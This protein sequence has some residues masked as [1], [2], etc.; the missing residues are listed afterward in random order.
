VD[1]V[2]HVVA[3]HAG[4]DARV[5]PGKF[6]R[7]AGDGFTFFRATASLFHKA[8]A[9]EADVAA[10]SPTGWVTGDMHIENFG[11]YKG[12]HRH[13]RLV[14]FDITDFDEAALAPAAVDL[15]RFLASIMAARA[16]LKLERAAATRLMTLAQ[17]TYAATLAEGKPF[18]MERETAPAPIS[19]LI[20]EVSARKRRVFLDKYS[21][22]RGSRRRLLTTERMLPLSADITPA[23]VREAARQL[24]EASDDAGYFRFRDARE[25]LAGTASL[26]RKRV[27]LLVRG[28]EDMDGNALLDLKSAHPSCVPA[29][30]GLATPAHASEAHRITGVERMAQAVPPAFLTPVTLDGR[31][32]V[33]RELQ[34]MQDR[35]DVDTLATAPDTLADA[36][37]TMA[38]VAAYAHLRGAGRAGAAPVEDWIAFGRSAAQD[39]AFVTLAT[40]LADDNHAAA[41]EFARAWKAGDPRLQGAV[42][43]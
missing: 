2:Q 17:A 27:V 33:A 24:A 16:A 20:V 6:A 4:R 7:M 41:R 18:Y 32:F 29:A 23:E 40:A 3:E 34:P 8:L 19:G 38:A 36:V 35:L 22:R 37:A 28:K 21:E 11:V 30:Y 43:G 26:G 9:R 14:Y 10:V 42:P 13:K 1:P 5:L 15:V 39:P 31:C 12:Q 25:R